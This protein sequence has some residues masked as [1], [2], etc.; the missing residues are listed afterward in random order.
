M[1][2][3]ASKAY[4]Y[5]A[6]RIMIYEGTDMTEEN[7]AILIED[8]YDFYTAKEIQKIY[9]QNIIFDS[10]EAFIDDKIIKSKINEQHFQKWKYY[11]QKVINEKVEKDMVL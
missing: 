7:F 10:Y 6:F 3:R 11:S 9:L 2:D 5:V 8:L 4:A 1:T